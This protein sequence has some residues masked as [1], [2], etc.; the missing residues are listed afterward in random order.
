M[1]QK[2]QNKNK[3]TNKKNLLQACAGV[4]LKVIQ[5]NLL[6]ESVNCIVKKKTTKKTKKQNKTLKYSLRLCLNERF[7]PSFLEFH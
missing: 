6:K 5:T 2:K 3:Q 7:F 4:D 1:G